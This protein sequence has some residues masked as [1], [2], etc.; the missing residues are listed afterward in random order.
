MASFKMI[1]SGEVKFTVTSKQENKEKL[2]WFKREIDRVK[3]T[4]VSKFYIKIYKSNR[5]TSDIFLSQDDVD[6]LTL[7]WKSYEKTA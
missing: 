5:K 2:N 1:L 3:E 7:K 6:S 4:S